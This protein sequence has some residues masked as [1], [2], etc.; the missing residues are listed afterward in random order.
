[1]LNWRVLRST[2]KCLV[3]T[4]KPIPLP[5]FI[6]FYRDLSH[7]TESVSQPLHLDEGDAPMALLPMT[8]RI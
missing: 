1:V 8:V 7:P 5:A 2:R 6:A 4:S 3:P